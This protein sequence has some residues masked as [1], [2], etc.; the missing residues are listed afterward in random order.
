[1]DERL[2]AAHKLGEEI[3]ST[4]AKCAARRGEKWEHLYDPHAATELG[5]LIYDRMT[6]T[7][8]RT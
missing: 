3:E 6:T 2:I 1:M 8:G 5:N 7:K 4:R